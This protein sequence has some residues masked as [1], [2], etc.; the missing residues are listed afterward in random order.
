[1]KR[2][3]VSAKRLGWLSEQLDA[4]HADGLVAEDQA[5]AI[6][7]RYEPDTRNALARLAFVLGAAFLGIGVLWLVATN[8]D[9]DEVSPL[10]RFLVVAALWLGF[11][12]AGTT[13]DRLGGPLRLLAALLFG[14]VVFQV[15]QSL[16][17][18]AYEPFLL[19]AWAG[20]ALA[21]AY[22]ARSVG[23][24]VVGVAAGIGW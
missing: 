5:R 13:F 8:V 12:V 11:T 6:R 16:Q 4:W 19:L 14:G 2:V 22:G 17:V 24:L 1:M 7:D 18:P 3:Q 21:L 9:Y 23:P 10:A 20:G 15:A